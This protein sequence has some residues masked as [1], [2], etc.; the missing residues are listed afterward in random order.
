MKVPKRGH[1]ESAIRGVKRRLRTTLKAVNQQAGKLLQRG[2][3]SEAE[4][5]VRVGR[6]IDDFQAKVDG[7]LSEWRAATARPKGEVRKEKT[8]L[9]R[10]YHPILR[11]LL[12][13]GGAAETS[14]LER[15]LPNFLD[16]EAASN[17]GSQG[18]PPWKTLV[19]RAR[20]PMIKEGF[21]ESVRG[22]R[23]QVSPSGRRAAEQAAPGEGPAKDPA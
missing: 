3:Y 6:A 14:Q 9:W 16:A 2:R 15:A 21:L 19:R 5:L 1:V 23:W 20:R 7:L 18:G 12:S 22:K 4:E 13:L 8:P 17:P 10:L 11:A